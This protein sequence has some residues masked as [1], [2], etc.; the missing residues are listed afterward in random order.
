MRPD[1]AVQARDS[2][3]FNPSGANSGS[4]NSTATTTRDADRQNSQPVLRRSPLA[5]K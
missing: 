2:Y 5:K 3:I 1:L 4:N